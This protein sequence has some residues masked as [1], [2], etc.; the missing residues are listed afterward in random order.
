M[1]GY[2]WQYT[3]KGFPNVTLTLV[4]STKDKDKYNVVAVESG[5]LM[6]FEDVMASSFHGPVQYPT[7]GK[8]VLPAP[9]DTP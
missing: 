2:Y 6:A 4:E 5:R 8:L 1:D 7:D 3:E 9:E